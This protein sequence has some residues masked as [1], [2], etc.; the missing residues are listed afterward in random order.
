MDDFGVGHS[1]MHCLLQFPLD[2]LKIDKALTERLTT[3][4]RHTAAVSALVSLARNLGIQLVA[5][6]IETTEQAVTLRDM[7]CDRMQG[8]LLSKP[9]PLHEFLRRN[10]GS[11]NTMAMSKAA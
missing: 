11:L 9:L 1:S 10:G 3:T 4:E 6:G 5:E 7:G 8:F 2:C